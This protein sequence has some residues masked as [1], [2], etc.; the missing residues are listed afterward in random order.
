MKNL[1]I[2]GVCFL[3]LALFCYLYEHTGVL[4]V[5]SR[6][7]QLVWLK[8]P[9]RQQPGRKTQAEHVADETEGK[10]NQNFVGQETE[11][12]RTYKRN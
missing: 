2:P 6:K 8:R 11:K 3:E 12:K 5:S 10:W 7:A 9:P 4:E 1:I